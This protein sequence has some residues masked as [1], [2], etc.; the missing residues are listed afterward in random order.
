MF[1]KH[2]LKEGDGLPLV[3]LHGFLGTSSDWEPLC[4]YLPPCPCIGFDLPGHG[5]SPFQENF[6][7]D[8]PRFHLIGYSMGGRIA[9]QYAAQHPEQVAS[10]TIMSAHPGLKTEQERRARWQQDQKWAQM[11]LERP[12]DEFLS[13]WYSQPI[14]QSFKPDLK[15]RRQQNIPALAKALL[16]YSL[17][18]Q[19]LLD[20]KNVLVGERDEKF[21]S[22]FQNPM[23]IPDVAHAIHLENPKA[24]AKILESMLKLV[25][26]NKA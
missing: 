22:L 10:L 15:K 13:L 7:I 4:S 9:A 5:H 25:P 12:I 14:F 26:L 19:P 18:K 17:A 16:H 8:L 20:L 1:A 11:L 23:I 21:R 24:V 3:F 2:N 6:T